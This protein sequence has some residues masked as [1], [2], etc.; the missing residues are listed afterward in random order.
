MSIRTAK[1]ITTMG[2]DPVGMNEEIII[3]PEFESLIPPLS[4]EEFDQ[5]E[6]NIKQDGI[7]DTLQTWKGILID[8][9]NRYKIATEW[10]LTYWTEEITL[11]DREAVRAWIIHNQLGR[12]NIEP[13]VR[14]ELIKKLNVKDAISKQAKERQVLGGKEKVVQN[15]AQAKTRDELAKMA[16]VSHDTFSK[17]EYL[18]AHADEPTKERLRNGEQSINSAYVETRDR[19]RK[20]LDLSAKASLEEAKERHEDFRDKKTVSIEE[21]QKDRKDREEIADGLRREVRNAIK[22]I[23]FFNAA[24][25]GG[26]RNFSILKDLSEDQ[27]A[28][29]RN[30]LRTAISTLRKIADSF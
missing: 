4:K 19:E 1:E 25:H 5:L 6:E 18:L 3:D 8:G 2:A 26:D 24:M 17:G 10:G 22:D 27:A 11:P 21:A 30:D 12:R 16:G 7:R 23:L 29:L 14:I 13:F 9:H 28:K 20:K 15:S